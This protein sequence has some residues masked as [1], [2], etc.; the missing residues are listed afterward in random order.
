MEE[1]AL[2]YFIKYGQLCSKELIIF[3]QESFFSDYDDI[4]DCCLEGWPCDDFSIV[5]IEFKKSEVFL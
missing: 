2:I 1:S 4:K 3:D 5:S